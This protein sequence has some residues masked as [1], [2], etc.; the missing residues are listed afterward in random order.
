MRPWLLGSCVFYNARGGLY[1]VS[2]NRGRRRVGGTV[3]IIFRN[4][5]GDFERLDATLFENEDRLQAYITANPEA[6]PL[7]ALDED[8]QLLMLKREVSTDSGR[9]DVLGIDQRGGIY[10]IE[11][12]L[13]SNPDK[14]NVVAQILDYG[15]S[16]W[17]HCAGLDDLLRKFGSSDEFRQ[18]ITDHFELEPIAAD[19]LFDALNA[20]L[21]NGVFQFIVLMDNIEPRLKDLIL[22]INQ[23]SQF[24]IY[25]VELKYYKKGSLEILA[26]DLHGAEVQKRVAKRPSALDAARQEFWQGFVDYAAG[27]QKYAQLSNLSIPRAGYGINILPQGDKDKTGVYLNVWQGRLEVAFWIYQNDRLYHYLLKQRKSLEKDFKEALDFKSERP[28]KGYTTI[29]LKTKWQADTEDQSG[30]F[31]W[32]YNT[33]GL[34]IKILPGYLTEFKN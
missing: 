31:E 20:N 17:R 23:N 9:V 32:L 18:K 11:T 19:E 2:Y 21:K 7:Y 27:E 4:K 34:F 6:I 15:A 1:G 13:H 3:S 28:S 14:R 30:Y 24:N 16:L 10:L 8:L 26:P 33:A 5:D 25:A 22:F 12:K 29:G